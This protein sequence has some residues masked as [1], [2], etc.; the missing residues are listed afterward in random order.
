ME[1]LTWKLVTSSRFVLLMPI[2]EFSWTAFTP[3]LA[4]IWFESQLIDV[5]QNRLFFN[6]MFLLQTTWWLHY[7]VTSLICGGL[8]KKVDLL[9]SGTTRTGALGRRLS[10]HNVFWKDSQVFLQ[11]D[12]ENSRFNYMQRLKTFM[13]FELTDLSGNSPQIYECYWS[14]C[15]N[16]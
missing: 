4:R 6:I 12:Q 10:N 11:T 9:Y 8:I 14:V 13:P 15:K 1:F 5:W 7:Y 3:T 16:T 2:S